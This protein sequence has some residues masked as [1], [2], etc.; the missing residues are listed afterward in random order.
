MTY[1]SWMSKGYLLKETMIWERRMAE[2]D[3]LKMEDYLNKL[4]HP[5]KPRDEFVRD[6]RQGLGNT[7][8]STYEEGDFGL[9]EKVFWIITGF[10]SAIVLL[11][12]GVRVIVNLVRKS[13]LRGRGRRKTLL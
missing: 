6:L 10:T 2:E 7:E 4:M 5:V 13:N 8:V 1:M 9:S 12:V 11:T 3:F